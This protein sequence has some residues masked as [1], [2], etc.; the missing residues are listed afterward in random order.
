SAG[1]WG[2]VFSPSLHAHGSTS[3]SS[4]SS[5]LGHSP[6]GGIDTIVRPFN[7]AE[8]ISASGTVST[9]G[10]TSNAGRIPRAYLARSRPCH[11]W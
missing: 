3:I 5:V 6:L 9:R 2:F 11:A 1:R 4:G 7:V 8:V 10:T